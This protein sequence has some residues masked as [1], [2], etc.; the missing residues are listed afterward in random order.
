MP[1]CGIVQGR[2]WQI[3]YVALETK[4]CGFFN[5]SWDVVINRVHRVST[6]TLRIVS[7][8]VFADAVFRHISGC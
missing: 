2:G 5:E 4:A 6:K 8:R 3:I 1:M 7:S